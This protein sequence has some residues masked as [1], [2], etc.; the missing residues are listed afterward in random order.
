MPTTCLKCSATPS[1]NSSAHVGSRRRLYGHHG[2]WKRTR[3]EPGRPIPKSHLPIPI[4]SHPNPIP[5]PSQSHL[6]IPSPDGRK[7]TE[8][9]T[10]TLGTKVGLWGS[11]SKEHSSTKHPTRHTRKALE[12][13]SAKHP[14]RHNRKASGLDFFI[15]IGVAE[16]GDHP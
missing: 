11:Q 14:I 3:G 9:D 5:I 16:D 4:Q 13:G 1:S 7:R 8:T 12:H 6:P 15:E 2:A 10:R